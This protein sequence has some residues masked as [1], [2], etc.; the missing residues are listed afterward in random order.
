MY[1]YDSRG[2]L[3]QQNVLDE[4]DHIN[5]SHVYEYDAAG[6]KIKYEVYYNDNLITYIL[7]NYADNGKLMSAE[8]YEQDTLIGI[9]K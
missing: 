3:I 1:V 9:E 2:L 4:T 7:Y 8:H 6:N 5:S